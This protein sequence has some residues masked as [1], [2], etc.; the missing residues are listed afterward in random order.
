MMAPEDIEDLISEIQ[1]NFQRSCFLLW[2]VQPLLIPS[3]HTL[4]T[5]L[6][7]FFSVSVPKVD[8]I[9]HRLGP[10][11]QEFKDLVYP[12]NYNPDSK[13]AAKR[14]TGQ[15][16]NVIRNLPT[17]LLFLYGGTIIQSNRI[18][19]DHMNFEVHHWLLG[20]P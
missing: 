6:S 3:T 15:N 14:K 4:C 18:S 19:I 8:Q 12:A 5:F 2:L 10:L 1:T 20:M 16:W 11:V 13:P 17:Y 9:D 7:L